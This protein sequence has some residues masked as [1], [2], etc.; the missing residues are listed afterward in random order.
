MAGYGIEATGNPLSGSVF[1]SGLSALTGG[2]TD[3]QPQT[4]AGEYSRT[5]GEFLPG[6][7]AFGGGSL[8]NLGRYALAPAVAS[9]T[10]GQASEDTALEPYARVVGALL[11]GFA[12][13]RIG[14]AKA[15]AP[16]SAAEIKR[17]AGYGDDMTNMLR[18]AR[19]T[20]QTYQN[21]V[22]DLWDDVRQAGTS[23]EVQQ[24]FGRTLANEMKLV[25]QEGAS[26]HSLERLRRALRSAGGGT[27]DTPN[28]AIANRL[29]EK[30]DDAV[31]NLSA[32]N[33][34]ASPQGGAPVLD[35]LKEARQ[36][37]RTGKKAEIIERAI[38]NG[39]DAKSGVENGLRGEFT[40]ILKNEKLMRGFTK[41]EQDA[42]R[43]AAKGDFSSLAMRW[44]GTFGVP[45]D[46]GRA[47]LGSVMGGGS[48][49]AIGS[50]LGGPV[51]AAVGGVALPAI[52]T[53]AK[54]GASRA[55]QN[56]A[57]IAESLIKA[58]P[59][60]Q[61]A[62]SAA[63]GARQVAGREAVIRALLQSQSAARVP[64]AREYA[65]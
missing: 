46:Q 37:Y 9:E 24:N 3:Y 12:G 28:Q 8:L 60:G 55:A 26:L 14:G 39:M 49:A 23:Y 10:A 52:G 35:V 20:E 62:F 1:R 36:I 16:P 56:Q 18:Q 34:A 41:A 43:L 42:I 17:S 33:V 51:G 44:L 27:L 63:Q 4:T 32:A 30:L 31:D 29:I 61:Q 38:R 5:I 25:Q 64:S 15:P 47:F 2:A 21:I 6:G 50:A 13:S 48:G 45:V 65:Q 22:K 57:A 53:A 58:G 11:G 40:K 7:A 54:I 59:Q 19:T